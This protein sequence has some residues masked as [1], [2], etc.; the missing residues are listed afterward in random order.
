[1]SDERRRV[2]DLLAKGKITVEEAEQLLT[3]LGEG[4]AQAGAPDHEGAQGRRRYLRI[5]VHK[6][7][8]PFEASKDVNIR[9]PL[10]LV[11]S[12]MRLGAFIP[13]FSG[14][15]IRQHLRE[16]GIDVDIE[17]LDYEQLDALLN[18]LGEM[19]IDVDNGR[20]TVRMRY[21]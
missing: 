9:I 4:R 13:G 15:R 16:R 10:P 18:E 1:M 5:M 2:L 17:K 14:D 3:A 6:A 7:A 12:G 8:E 11:R 20:K 19:T 21:E